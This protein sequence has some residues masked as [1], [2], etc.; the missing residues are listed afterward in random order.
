MK[1]Y[2]CS[3]L[4]GVLMV[5]SAAAGQ[6]SAAEPL[7]TSA[8]DSLKQIHVREGYEL[9]LVASEP[10]I[11]DPVAIDWGSDG[12][13]WVV[14]MADY[15]LGIDGQ[16]MPGGRIRV[17]RDNDGDGQYDTAQLFADGL[18]FPNGILVWG[19]GILV[20][21]APQILYLK[22]S[23][24]DGQA[25][26]R[27][28]LYEGF[29]EGNQQLRVNGLRW[30][31]DNWIHCASGSHASSYGQGNQITSTMTGE[32]LQIGSRDFRIRP[33]T[34]EIDPQSGPSQY[35]RNRDDWGNWFG[36]QNSRPLWHY[37]LA[38]HHI[39]RNPHFA[40]PDPKKP[41]VT[42]LNPPVY[43]AKSPQK[44]FHSFEQSGRFT[45]ACSGMIYRDEL[46]FQRH[47]TDQHAFTCEPFHNLVQHNII[48]P[49][50]VSF[51][52]RRDP[53]ET[54]YDFFASRD[55][56]CRPV[57]A[58]TGPDGALWVVDM[59]RYMIEHPQ[60]LPD[61][62]KEELRPYFR[63]GENHGRI[64]RV[65]P[66][67]ATARPLPHLDG[68]SVL[69][70]IPLLESPNGWQRDAAQLRLVRQNDPSTVVPLE[71]MARSGVRSLA[72]LH[73]LCTLEGMGVL[74]PETLRHTLHD[75]HFGV[76][77]H[78]V[79]IAATGLVNADDLAPLARDAN[80][81]VR[82]EL[83]A[84]L[85]EFDDPSAARTLATL[86]ADS[87][88]DSYIVANVFS[89]LNQGNI[90][91]V[92]K[93]LIA[94]SSASGQVK[95]EHHRLLVQLFRQMAA[96]GD[97]RAVRETVASVCSSPETDDNSWRL[98]GLA[99]LLD[100]I[101]QRNGS[102]A[103]LQADQRELIHQTI[104]F[105]REL[106][107][108]GSADLNPG[109]AGA[110]RLLLREPDESA[111]DL[112]QLANLLV[113]Q[114]TVRL[115]LAVVDRVADQANPQIAEILLL[116]WTSHGPKLRSRI[117][118]V[119]ASRATW[120]RSLLNRVTTGS[121][122]SAEISP[123]NHA[124]LM[125]TT[126][127]RLQAAWKAV[128]NGENSGNRRQVIDDYSVALELAGDLVRGRAVFKK[129]CSACH[130]LDNVGHDVGP[131]L[132]SLTDRK[133]QSLLRAMLDPNAA[134]E[135]RFVTYVAVT[136][137]GR[138]RNGIM[139]TETG[140]SITLLSGESKQETILRSDI[141]ELRALGKSLMPEGIEKDL[142]VQAVA[143]LIAVIQASWRPSGSSAS[144]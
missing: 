9:Q 114:S 93:S 83:A 65:V 20:T 92:L 136:R 123:A 132:N 44:R 99:A 90:D 56:W 107:T 98:S 124:L 144:E 67:A 64:Y 12:S 88:N 13:L 89:S 75:A 23:D 142:S 25:D 122:L 37:V 79:R 74:K 129:H 110:I 52:F 42:P 84:T 1:R 49:A 30:G 61:D 116:G 133:P 4:V 22:D 127:E 103:L 10:L 100:G 106:I 19:D 36:V 73:A 131:R 109:L 7:P 81:G 41:V 15:P 35:G 118:D 85:G 130:R 102:A 128:L 39:R 28:T 58:R 82:L 45:S 143:D 71:R 94:E 55:R 69:E 11:K 111:G 6:N 40:P 91:D 105:A 14:E 134:V 33:R 125:S 117:L 80:A 87:A 63:H 54:E 60:W 108:A 113:P 34:G 17:L 119:L 5:T 141:E 3:L 53:A 138:T 66:T 51:D 140:S 2:F 47:D 135:A 38:D 96:V 57:M 32:Q 29:L 24:G 48:F 115:Q 50:G 31:L 97:A 43:P 78:A 77:R 16:G 76:R 101:N 139:A 21:A 137:D 86:A 95:E 68:L 8:S 26:V 126:D 112:E 121:I 70:L 120:S 104:S 18:N 62:G 27:Q 46:L 72:R 59:Y